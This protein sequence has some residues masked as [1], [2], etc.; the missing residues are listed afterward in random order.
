MKYQYISAEMS[1]K[2]AYFRI[3]KILFTEKFAKMSIEAKMFYG[4]L[5]DR[6]DLSVK[7]GWIDEN[8]HVYVIFTRDELME[9]IGCATAKAAKIMEEV[10]KFSL[11]KK[12]V[13]GFGKPALLYVMEFVDD[14]IESNDSANVKRFE[15]QTSRG[16]KIEL[17]EVR[18]SN[19]NNTDINNPDNI[20]T[21]SFITP[22]YPLTGE[23]SVDDREADQGEE[24]GQSRHTTNADINEIVSMY[25]E[26]CV[27]LPRV[28]KMTEVRKKHV[29]ARIRQFGKDTIREALE[30]TRDSDFLSGRTSSWKGATFDWLMGSENNMV[31]VLEGNYENKKNTAGSNSGRYRSKLEMQ[32]DD[33]NQTVDMMRRLREEMKDE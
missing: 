5:L 10:V 27:D 21:D 12:K 18:K 22:P 23:G 33:F 1:K 7:N 8:G 30:K 25:N 29:A 15:N 26:I 4:M 6:V 13:Q 24:V 9:E 28:Q 16:S 11:V 17:Q 19:T 31:K 2:Y 20:K 14:N 3:P 32:Q